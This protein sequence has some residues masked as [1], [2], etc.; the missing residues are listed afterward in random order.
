MNLEHQKI[1]GKIR[2]DILLVKKGYFKSRTQARASILS[3]RVR[4][5]K[6]RVIQKSNEKWDPETLF[7]ISE[8]FPYVSRGALK[9][10]P[11]LD[12][13]RPPL[14]GSIALDLGAST[15]GFTDLLLQRGVA[16]VYA[17][18]AGYGQLHY[19]LR[20]DPRVVCLERVNARYLSPTHVTDRVDVLTADLSFISLT[21]VLPAAAKFLKSGGWCFILIKPQFEAK[22][23]EIGK[24]GVVRSTQVSNRVVKN[25]CTFA[26]NTMGW[27]TLDTL[28]SPIKG[29]KGNLEYI[30]VF[31]SDS[32]LK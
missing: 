5:G 19:R 3:G 24:G 31:R 32:S 16:K 27:I 6:D 29:P 9:I 23:H 7:T 18:D 25:I 12:K 13:Y 10:I 1:S 15:G 11:A 28:A 17:V 2:A 14:N 30:G 4:V 20:V 22:R 26:E 21:K 8:P